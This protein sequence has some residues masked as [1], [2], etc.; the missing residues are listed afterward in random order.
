M[1]AGTARFRVG[2]ASLL[3]AGGVVAI[4]LT[5]PFATA[6]PANAARLGLTDLSVVG[7]V[8]ACLAVALAVAVWSR[9]PAAAPLLAGVVTVVACV[10]SCA[11][12]WD[13]NRSTPTAVALAESPTAAW[14][15]QRPLAGRIL[16]QSAHGQDTDVVEMNRCLG[17]NVPAT[18]RLPAVSGYAPLAPMR[19]RAIEYGVLG[20]RTGQSMP[21]AAHRNL[22][23]LLRT[24]AVVA[25]PGPD[26][27]PYGLGKPAA[28]FGKTA[29]HWLGDVGPEAFLVGRA[30]MVA[31]PRRALAFVANPTIDLSRIACVEAPLPQPLTDAT[32]VGTV[33]IM[34]TDHDELGLTV[35]AQRPALV[36]VSRRWDPGWRAWLDG[37]PV[38]V[39]RTD[40][41]VQGV[42]VP[43]GEH[44]VRL[45]YRPTSL[46]LG[47]AVS[48]AGLVLLLVLLML[49]RRRRNVEPD[50]A[51]L[52][53]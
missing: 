6:R 2:V 40:Y 15:E 51:D 4:V 16:V 13:F 1:A 7:P 41:L 35:R 21:P 17:F 45:A 27:P 31:Q 33:E 14:L 34:H 50:L 11:S 46:W 36:V 32:Q 8:T 20:G 18:Y 5:D 38:S 29:V 37:R 42:F 44:R 12:L 30:D 9:R 22:L 52:P 39:L 48:A 23:R 10:E 3:V 25:T 26:W 24:Q 43:A 47:A 49:S 53:C 28:T 19:I